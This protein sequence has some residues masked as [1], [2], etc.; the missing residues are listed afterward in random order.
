[1]KVEVKEIEQL[2]KELSIEVPAETVNNKMEEKFLELRNTVTLKGYRK[3]KA[4]LNVIKSLYHDQVKADIAEDIIKA[5]YPEAVRENTLKVASYPT[6]TGFNFNEDGSIKYTATVEV[7]PE[8]DSVEYNNLEIKSSDIE[9]KDEEVNEV[10]EVLRKR[11]SDLR[12]LNREVHDTDV[13]VVDIEKVYDPGNVI[14]QD[15]FE[16]SE[17]DL[18]NKLTVKEFKDHLPGMKIGDVKEIEVKYGEDYPDKAFA[19][20]HLK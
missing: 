6:V 11:K 14:P 10:V 18:G 19:G 5:T 7:F 16:G 20:A 3:G 2:V 1:V 13:V 9:I 12:P 8:I 4:P 17:V 15:K